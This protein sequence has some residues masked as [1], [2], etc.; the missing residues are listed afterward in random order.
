MRNRLWKNALLSNG[1]IVNIFVSDGII[2]SMGIESPQADVIT[3]LKGALVIPGIIDPHVHVRDMGLHQK[4]TW[5]S[6][7]SAAAAGGITTIFD[8]PNTIPPTIDREGLIAKRNSAAQSLVNWGIH[9]GAIPSNEAEI[10]AADNIGGIK[11]FLAKSSSSFPIPDE[12]QSRKIFEISADI[13]KP[14]L[15]HSECQACVDDYSTKFKHHIL[16]H[17]KIRNS[18]CAAKSTKMII[19]LT[20][21]VGNALYIAHISTREELDMVRRA[22]D[23]GVKI[24]VEATPHHLLLDESVLERAGNYGKVNPPIRSKEDREALWDALID[25]TVDTIGTDHAPHQLEEKNAPYDQSP[26]GF[27][28]LETALPL[29]L[30]E[31]NKGCLDLSRLIELTSKNPSEIFKIEKRGQLKAGYFA[32]FSVISLNINCLVNA[33]NFFTKAK[34]SPFQNTPLSAKVIST[35]VNGYEVYSNE[36]I[37]DEQKG[38]EIGY[39]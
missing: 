17:N 4:E 38:H 19:K 15:V 24:F 18:H 20:E 30:S 8:M 16:N 29:L 23:R 2:Q 32:D 5:L 10:R 7:S 31:V 33:E 39:F 37:N 26:S 28:G 6:A 34:Y 13:N 27:P 35:I 21:E 14:I 11:L 1:K 12:E 25:G 36:L 9:F 3:D 22:K